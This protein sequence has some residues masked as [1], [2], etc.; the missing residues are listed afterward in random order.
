MIFEIWDQWTTSAPKRDQIG[1]VLLIGGS[2]R[3]PLVRE[4]VSAYFGG[5]PIRW[6]IDPDEAVTL[7]A[8]ILA[9]MEAHTLA[10]ATLYERAKAHR[11]SASIATTEWLRTYGLR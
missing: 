8:A 11:T 9:G 10:A 1:T 2:T 4:F 6:E 5:R 3:V 7:G